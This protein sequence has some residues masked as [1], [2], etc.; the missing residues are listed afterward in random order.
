MPKVVKFAGIEASQRDFDSALKKWG[1]RSNVDPTP[2]KVWRLTKGGKRVGKSPI[3]A[4]ASQAEADTYVERERQEGFNLEVEGPDMPKIS[5][6]RLREI[7]SEELS[8]AR[9]LHELASTPDHKA[10]A[11]VAT[12]ASALLAA[13]DKFD[14][15]TAEHPNVINATSSTVRELRTTLGKIIE[16]PVSYARKPA[17]QKVVKLRVQ[18]EAE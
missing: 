6:S 17:T 5:E 11:Q 13:L 12:A 8:R 1:R 18:K 15:A 9:Q 10:T 16:A 3:R 2:W 7:I 14:K 4:F